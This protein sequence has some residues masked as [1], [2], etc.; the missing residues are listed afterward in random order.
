[1]VHDSA[2]VVGS[3]FNISPARHA[4]CVWLRVQNS[5]IT[6]H[7]PSA[8]APNF[9]LG[10]PCSTVNQLDSTLHSTASSMTTRASKRAA[11][12][13]HSLRD[14][15]RLTRQ[16][17]FLRYAVASSSMHEL[18]VCTVVCSFLG[19]VRC[20]DR[21]PKQKQIKQHVTESM[22]RRPVSVCPQSVEF[23]PN[24]A[25][26][27]PDSSQL[28]PKSCSNFARVRPKSVHSWSIAGRRWPTSADFCPTSSKSGHIGS[29]SVETCP[30]SGDIKP[31]LVD[32][33]VKRSTPAEFCPS[34]T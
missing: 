3:Y 13:L 34:S 7:R 23:R 29:A 15:L 11:V 31:A 12:P 24:I 20:R 2:Q 5:A 9:T 6:G 22:R 10:T 17:P 14:Y 26:T 8:M 1:M 32:R 27:R 28:G 33:R 16:S 4:A 19:A 21:A 30:T 25:Q 18:S